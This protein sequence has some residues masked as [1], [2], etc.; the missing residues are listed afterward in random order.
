MKVLAAT[1]IPAVFAWD[2]TDQGATWFSSAD[3]GTAGSDYEFC[4]TD[5]Q[6][7]INLISYQEYEGLDIM[8]FDIV[9]NE[10]LTISEYDWPN[11]ARTY[12]HQTIKYQANP[13]GDVAGG[14]D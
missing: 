10:K 7:P 13:T 4:A 14:A 1:A 9:Y 8:N 11:A 3:P 5:S 6:S 12:G 2:Y